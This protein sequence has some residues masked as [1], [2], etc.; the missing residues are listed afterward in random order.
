MSSP[1]FEP[2]A[3]ASRSGRVYRSR[4]SH[5]AAA[6]KSSKLFCL[7]SEHPALVPRLAVLAAAADVGNGDDPALAPARGA[8]S[9]RTPASC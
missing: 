2:P 8:A 1:P 5:S 9:G 4:I 6:M 7:L 3:A